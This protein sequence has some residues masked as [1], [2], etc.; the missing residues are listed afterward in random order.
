M[1]TWSTSA[2][3]SRAVLVG[4]VLALATATASAAPLAVYDVEALAEGGAVVD[5]G[6]RAPDAGIP[7]TVT[8][9]S[10]TGRRIA[11]LLRR[12]ERCESLCGG[13]DTPP[14]HQAG[15][16]RTADGASVEVPAL[17]IPGRHELDVQEVDFEASGKQYRLLVPK[18]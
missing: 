7:P 13:M 4:T 12:T 17:A 6:S 16:Y 8:L 10:A 5:F 9:V 14:C 11:H 15:L 3:T 2:S 18:R 1:A